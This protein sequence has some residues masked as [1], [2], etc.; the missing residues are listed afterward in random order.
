TKPIVIWTQLSSESSR[1]LARLLE[2]VAGDSARISD[3]ECD[4]AA[5]RQGANTYWRNCSVLARAPRVGARRMQLFGSI[6]VR[7][8]RAKFVSFATDF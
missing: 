7:D 3:L 1:G 8:G 5:E 6:I 2:R 4:V